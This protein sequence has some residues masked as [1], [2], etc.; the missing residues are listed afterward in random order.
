MDKKD[1]HPDNEVVKSSMLQ[2]IVILCNDN[3]IIS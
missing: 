2:K 3:I 1:D